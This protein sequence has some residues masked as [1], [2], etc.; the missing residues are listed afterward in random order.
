M[1]RKEIAV[2]VPFFGSSYVSSFNS[3]YLRSISK[4]L[5]TNP[6]ASS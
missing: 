2:W 5:T 6:L 4:S 1:S 3:L